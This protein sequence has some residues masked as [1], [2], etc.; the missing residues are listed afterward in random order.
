MNTFEEYEQA[1][2]SLA[3]YPGQ[4]GPLGMMYVALKGA[5]EAGEF[6]EHAGKA[7]RDDGYGTANNNLTD[8]RHALMCKEVG[9]QLWYL[10]AKANELGTNLSTIAAQNIAK[11]ND[12]KDRGVLS[13][14]GDTR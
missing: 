13:G 4:G 10:A 6:A 9:D 7:I 5:G 12:R 2:L 1:A 11:L 3:V 8:E 14:S